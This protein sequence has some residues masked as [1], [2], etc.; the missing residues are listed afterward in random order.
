M[1]EY[2]LSVVGL[3]ELSTCCPEIVEIVL[4]A[5]KTSPIDFGIPRHGGKR[6]AEKQNELFLAGLSKMDGVKK[7]SKHQTGDAFDIIAY[8]PA[9]GGYTYDERY[10]YVIA[11]HILGTAKRLGYELIWGRDWDGDWDLSDQTFNDYVHFEL[12]RKTKT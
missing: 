1:K 3:S 5:I 7:K 6:T 4:E 9:V 2:K 10:Y 12:V 11:G 8:V